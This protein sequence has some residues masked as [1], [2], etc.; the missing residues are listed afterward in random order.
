MTVWGDGK[1]YQPDWKRGSMSHGGMLGQLLEVCS[2]LSLHQPADL[3]LQ[4]LPSPMGNSS[5]WGWTTDRAT[6]LA[7][8][9]VALQCRRPDTRPPLCSAVKTCWCLRLP[10]HHGYHVWGCHTPV[11]GTSLSG[12]QRDLWLV[13]MQLV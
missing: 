13:G 4:H 3:S 5:G 9:D 10:S 2:W 11:Q 1:C 7:N 8:V 12:R 6:I